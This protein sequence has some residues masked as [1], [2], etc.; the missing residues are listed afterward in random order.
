MLVPGARAQL[1]DPL[2]CPIRLNNKLAKRAALQSIAESG[3]ATPTDQSDAV[4]KELAAR[5][6]RTWLVSKRSPRSILPA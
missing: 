6:E 1:G 5:L 3:D 2:N 4:F